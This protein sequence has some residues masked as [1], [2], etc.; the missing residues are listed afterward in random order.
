MFQIPE[1]T[2]AHLASVTNR[3]EKHGDEDVPADPFA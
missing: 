1:F 2:E 3:I